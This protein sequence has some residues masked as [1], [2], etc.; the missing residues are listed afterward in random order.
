MNLPLS[1]SKNG[2]LLFAFAV[3]TAGLLSVTYQSTKDTIAE[4]ERRAAEKALLEIVP[5]NRIDHDLLL[6]TLAIPESDLDTLGLESGENIHIARKDGK[7]IAVIVPAIAPDGYS[8]DI[9]MIVGVNT[10][11]SIAGVRVLT[12]SETP[13]LGDKIDLKK[14]NWITGF[15]GKS[16]EQP[17]PDM[18]KVKKDGGAFDQL[19]GATITPRAMV[20][21]IR[22]VL[23]FVRANET[24]L[25]NK[26]PESNP[27][28]IATEIN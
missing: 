26:N 10:D 22:K 3:V 6:D 21:Q 12:H 11:G 18:W 2:L 4:A 1:I 25:F 20:R 9:K 23:E 27:K 15:N 28:Q 24:Y 7:I 16:L 8:G 14:S 13:G 5:A 19:T 17:T